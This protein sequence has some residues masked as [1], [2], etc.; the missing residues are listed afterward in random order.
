MGD[1]MNSKNT[2]RNLNKFKS[3]T[4]DSFSIREEKDEG[5]DKTIRIVKK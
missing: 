5:F 2:S 3:F 1:L 4:D